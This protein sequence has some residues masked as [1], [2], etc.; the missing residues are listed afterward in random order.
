MLGSGRW[1]LLLPDSCQGK[2]K[3]LKQREASAGCRSAR[4]GGGGRLGRGFS[5]CSAAGV[6]GGEQALAAGLPWGAGQGLLLL[7]C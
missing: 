1:I 4:G 7:L 3:S 5:L 2:K 6:V